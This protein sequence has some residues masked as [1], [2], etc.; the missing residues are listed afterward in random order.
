MLQA[1]YLILK[2]NYDDAL[3]IIKKKVVQ[4]TTL[5]GRPT[6]PYYETKYYLKYLLFIL[7]TINFTKPETIK[8]FQ[9]ICGNDETPL[10]ILEECYQAVFSVARFYLQNS[11]EP[12]RLLI[13]S[14]AS[15]S[16]S[17]NLKASGSSPSLPT[18]PNAANSNDGQL[19]FFNIGNPE[20][21]RLLSEDLDVM[22]VL[23]KYYVELSRYREATCF[24][25]EGL[26]LTQLHYCTRRLTQFLLHQIHTDLIASSL[27]EAIIRLDKAEQLIV[28]QTK[29]QTTKD[30]KS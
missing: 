21:Y 7:S 15:N 19:V 24:I 9:S 16:S 12:S 1:H 26:D 29:S 10:S 8:Q 28:F 17:N 25:R 2:Q 4:S 13:G 18:T 5:A 22:Q 11:M 20:C 30:S 14:S 3:K 23:C 6:A 27:N